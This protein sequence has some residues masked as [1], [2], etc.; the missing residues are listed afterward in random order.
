MGMSTIFVVLVVA[1]TQRCRSLD[2]GVADLLAYAHVVEKKE[3]NSLEG[4]NDNLL[5]A[6]CKAGS[7]LTMGQRVFPHELSSGMLRLVMAVE[8]VDGP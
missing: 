6:F 4:T 3:N 2:L 8:V 7:Q 1:L 5:V